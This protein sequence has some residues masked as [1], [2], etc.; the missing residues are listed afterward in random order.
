[1]PTICY[2]VVEAGG[3]RELNAFE[4]RGSVFKSVYVDTYTYGCRQDI[5]MTTANLRDHSQP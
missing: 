3:Q 2:A 5:D 1:M 4:A